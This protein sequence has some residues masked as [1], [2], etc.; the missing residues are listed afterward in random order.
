MSICLLHFKSYALTQSP[1]DIRQYN[2]SKYSPAIIQI[3]NQSLSS[4]RSFKSLQ[5]SDRV[6]LLYS[7][8][9]Y[10]TQLKLDVSKPKNISALNDIMKR[11]LNSSTQ[12]LLCRYDDMACLAKKPVLTPNT[13][14]RQDIKD[15]LGQ[16]VKAGQQFEAQAFFTTAW[17]DIDEQINQ[18]TANSDAERKKKRDI[19]IN[20]INQDILGTRLTVEKILAQKIQNDAD[21]GLWMAIYG[22]DDIQGTMKHVYGAI[23]ER[24]QS[25]KITQAVVDIE[26]GGGANSFVREY[27][28]VLDKD[29]NGTVV[30]KIIKFA[31]DNLSYSYMPPTDLS[32]WFFG[33][34]DWQK[35]VLAY[36]AQYSAKNKNALQIENEIFPQDKQSKESED[37]VWLMGLNPSVRQDVITAVR[38]TY[39]Y[40]GTLN[41]VQML[42][43]NI[44]SNDQAQ[45]H[46]EM[47]TKG[48]MHNKFMIMQ[49][50]KGE[51]FV[52]TGTANITQTCMGN[53]SNANMS[54]YIKN[55]AIAD[56]FLTE[57]QEMFNPVKQDQKD[58]LT[59]LF[60]NK[61]RPNTKRY[62]V[63][64]D[65]TE[66]AVHFSPTDDGEHRSIIPTIL[67]AQAGDTI[68]ISMFGG[69]GIEYVRAI[70]KAVSN[71]A[72]VRI[73]MDKLTSSGLTMWPKSD[74][75]NLLE[76]NPYVQNPTGSVEIRYSSWLGLNHHKTATLQRK[77]G[78]TEFLIIGSQNWS[79]EGNDGNDENMLT[80]RNKLSSI[81]IADQ[82]NEQFDQKMWV[83]SDPISKVESSL[84]EKNLNFSSPNP[85]QQRSEQ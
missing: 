45:A 34:A 82:F 28:V 54:I 41:L 70:Q 27:D 9:N 22:I 3:V 20:Q 26:D 68:R 63:F 18:I 53:E 31:D 75:A 16:P 73:V 39:Q 23:A 52:W 62:F 83:L 56:T 65:G 84:N 4:S 32:H 21:Q 15:D 44:Q 24:K 57:F 50:Q 25:Q 74:I 81:K 48:I 67:S 60:H 72:K 35:D 47:P 64:D 80:I 46:I 13:V 11:L 19:I 37:F 7:F 6:K 36:G 79:E 38:S 77:N 76:Q 59:G 49:N 85:R 43:S 5:E 17:A 69:S 33:P 66:V 55:D 8:L 10:L 1:F 51:K 29:A 78:R 12:F 61:K 42:N 40:D 71:G 2:L 14:W 58:L 30:P